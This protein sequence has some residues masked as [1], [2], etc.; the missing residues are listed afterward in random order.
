MRCWP[1]LNHGCIQNMFQSLVIMNTVLSKLLLF[2]YFR[3]T[4]FWGSSCSMSIC[5]NLFIIIKKFKKRL[6]LRC[7]HHFK[8]DWIHDMDNMRISGTEPSSVWRTEI[9]RFL[10]WFRQK[11]LVWV[12]F[13]S[14]EDLCR[15]IVLIN[16][17][18]LRIG[19]R[20]YYIFRIVVARPRVKPQNPCSKSQ[21]LNNYTVRWHEQIN[22]SKNVPQ[23]IIVLTTK[24]SH[25][26]KT[27]CQF[28]VCQV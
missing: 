14:L 7:I 23:E 13:V 15:F 9:I 18:I 3:I 24:R 16:S 10:C 25:Y 22:V 27:Q 4:T 11:S 21:K 1:P 19:S 5:L 12:A 8:S 28:P 20:I 2:W 17:V 6:L 26:C